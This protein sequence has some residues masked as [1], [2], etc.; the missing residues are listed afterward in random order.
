[1]ATSPEKFSKKA[2]SEVKSAV[3]WFK[4]VGLYVLAAIVI[5]VVLYFNVS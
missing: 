3:K 4:A 2:A 1:M 5:G